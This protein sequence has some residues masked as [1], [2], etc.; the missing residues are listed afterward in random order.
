[1]I[2]KSGCLG[3]SIDAIASRKQNR[4]VGRELALVFSYTWSADILAAT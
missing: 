1:M 4:P 3:L 2:K